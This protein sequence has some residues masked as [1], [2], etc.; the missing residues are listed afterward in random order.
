MVSL[1]V[2]KQL[3][4]ARMAKLG[5]LSFEQDQ[6]LQNSQGSTTLRGSEHKQTIHSSGSQESQ[7]LYLIRVQGRLLLLKLE[8]HTSRTESVEDYAFKNFRFLSCNGPRTHSLHRGS[9][10]SVYDDVALDEVCKASGEVIEH[11]ATEGINYMKEKAKMYVPEIH[12]VL[13][14]S[15]SRGQYLFAPEVKEYRCENVGST[16]LEFRSRPVNTVGRIKEITRTGSPTFAKLKPVVTNLARVFYEMKM[17]ILGF[18]WIIL[19]LVFALIMVPTILLY[20]RFIDPHEQ[21]IADCYCKLISIPRNLF[22]TRARISTSP[23]S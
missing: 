17:W 16:R 5:R 20:G 10:K 6:K 19:F 8:L 14:D 13:K 11:P 9:L 18:C 2:C 15:E 23:D 1:G 22:K 4:I 3:T 21:Q 12:E 7:Y